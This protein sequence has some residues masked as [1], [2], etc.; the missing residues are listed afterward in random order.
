MIQYRCLMQIMQL[1]LIVSVLLNAQG[2]Y[3]QEATIAMQLVCRD[4]LPKPV[5]RYVPPGIGFCG[6]REIMNLE[7]EVDKT[8]RGIQGIVLIADLKKPDFARSVASLSRTHTI[9]IKHCNF[10]E[11][12]LLIQ[13]GDTIVFENQDPVPIDLIL[14]ALLNES[15]KLIVPPNGSIEH[16]LDEAEPAFVR[17]D[18]GERP[19]MTINIYVLPH[20]FAGVSDSTGNVVIHNLPEKSI[21]FKL[22]HPLTKSAYGIKNVV[23]EG[24]QSFQVI[25]PFEMDLGKGVNDLGVVA[26]PLSEF[27][28]PSH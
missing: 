9:V 17:V 12:V 22:W 18:S 26:V 1:P 6:G 21:K 10:V 24:R 19:W 7:V 4:S 20:R 11:Q 25:F 13:A 28:R 8:S 23:R 16:K 14:N 3:S 27:R 15:T 5:K 2:L